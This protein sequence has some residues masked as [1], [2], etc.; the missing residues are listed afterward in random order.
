[1]LAEVVCDSMHDGGCTSIDHSTWWSLMVHCLGRPDAFGHILKRCAMQLSASH[2][3]P[4]GST[5]AVLYAALACMSLA[6]DLMSLREQSPAGS[7][8]PSYTRA[9]TGLQAPSPLQS[10]WRS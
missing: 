8:T 5:V 10:L 7:V 3:S 6:S 1:M 2:M 4:Q 9:G